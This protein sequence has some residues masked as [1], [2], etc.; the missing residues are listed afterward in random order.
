MS[1]NN[2]DYIVEKR[3]TFYIFYGYNNF[4][5]N[6][7]KIQRLNVIVIENIKP[8]TL[9]HGI[10]IDYILFTLA[11]K[12]YIYKPRLNVFKVKFT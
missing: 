6:N 3:I 12:K 9:N 4:W 7:K 5:S 11:Y 2:V 10:M 8:C 1:D